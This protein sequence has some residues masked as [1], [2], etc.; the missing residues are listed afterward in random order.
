MAF[1]EADVP[2]CFAKSDLVGFNAKLL[3]FHE[4]QQ[5]G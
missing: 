1:G 3:E 5:K 4:V 2:L